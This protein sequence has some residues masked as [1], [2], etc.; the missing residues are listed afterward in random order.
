MDREATK[1][2]AVRAIKLTPSEPYNK[3]VEE[4]KLTARDCQEAPK[5]EVRCHA[6]DAGHLEVC[7]DSV[8]V[9]VGQ[10]IRREGKEELW[11]SLLVEC[12]EQDDGS[13]AVEVVICHP[14]WDEP[15][16]IASI[17]SD[18]SDENAAEPTLRCDFQQKHL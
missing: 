17:Q 5:F 3:E 1:N 18:P 15:L 14:D 9:R 16:R 7:S 6:G 12:K 2:L 13:L 11:G 10:R 8:S 4:P